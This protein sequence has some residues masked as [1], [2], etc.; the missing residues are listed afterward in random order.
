V[1]SE[2]AHLARKDVVLVEDKA[3]LL[4]AFNHPA[5]REHPF[6]YH[7]NILEHEDAVMMVQYVCV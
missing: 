6:M 2:Q 4:V 5:T 1:S 3:E 7:C